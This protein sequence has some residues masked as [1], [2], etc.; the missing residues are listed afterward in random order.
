MLCNDHMNEILCRWQSKDIRPREGSLAVWDVK[1]PGIFARRRSQRK[2]AVAA[3]RRELISRLLA[4]QDPLFLIHESPQ[5]YGIPGEW[6]L[7]SE[8]TWTVPADFNP[9]QA[10]VE[11]WLSLGNWTFYTAPNP[12]ERDWPDPSRCSALDLLVWM[13]TNSVKA[14]IDSF[15]DDVTWVV[16][17]ETGEPRVELRRLMI[18]A[19][20]AD[21]KG[22]SPPSWRSIGLAVL[23][24]RPR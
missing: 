14:L 15:H 20:E 10:A 16:A 1:L 9:N 12:A 2:D 24:S 4:C 21:D 17:F 6:R 8:A 18:E 22:T 23:R 11:S 7:A 3:C 13:K 5:D 19:I